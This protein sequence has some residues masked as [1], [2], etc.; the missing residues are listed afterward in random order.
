[1]ST[2]PEVGPQQVAE[3]GERIQ[4]NV[5]QAVKAP[6]AVIREVLVALMA[7]GHVLIEDFPG[8]GKT[9]LARALARSIDAE[10][11]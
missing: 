10:H 8:V 5:G 7:G 2:V 3:L 4:R 9:A 11:A 6:P 1:M